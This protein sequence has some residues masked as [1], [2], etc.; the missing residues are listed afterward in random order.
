MLTLITVSVQMLCEVE[1]P[2]LHDD[3]TDESVQALGTLLNVLLDVC[4]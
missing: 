2:L 4:V 3:V 1:M